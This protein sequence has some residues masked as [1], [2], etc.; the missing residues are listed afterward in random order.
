MRDRGR[1]ELTGDPSGGGAVDVRDEDERSLGGETTR[2]GAADA[3]AGARH[4]GSPADK[5]A[6]QALVV[7]RA[8]S[9]RGPGRR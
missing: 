4:D 8:H 9:V 3:G 1:A 6:G 7:G 5:A 2:D